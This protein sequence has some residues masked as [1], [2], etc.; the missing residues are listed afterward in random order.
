MNRRTALSLL[1]AG[2]GYAFLGAPQIVFGQD[3]GPV[4]DVA[5][6]QVP[7]ALD[8]LLGQTNPF[9]RTLQNVYDTLLTVDYSGDGALQPALAE[10]WTRVDGKTIDLVLRQ[11]VR[12]HDGSPLTVD[13]VIFSFG[14]ER[15]TNPDSPG[16][17]TAQQ[18]LRTI[19]TVEAVD[20][21]TIRVTSSADD[22][23]LE[24]RLT[25]WGSQIVSKAAFEAAGGFE[26]FGHAPVGTGPFSVVSL[27]P[28]LLELKAFADYWNGKPDIETL[29]YRSSPELSSRIA[30]VASGDFD[31]VVDVPV[32]QFDAVTRDP[33][34]EIVGGP[35]ASIRVIKFDTRNEVLKDVRVRKALALAVDRQA[36]VDALWG[37][38]VTIPHGHQLEE[39]GALYT[40]DRPGYTYDPE[41]AKRL[42]AEAGYDGTPIPYRIRAAAYGPELATAQVLVAM[43]NAVGVNIDLQIVENFGQM[44][45]YPGVGMRNGVDPILVADPLFGL[46]RSHDRGEAEIWSNEEFFRAGETLQTSLDPDVRKAAFNRMMDIYDFEDPPAFILHTMGTFYGKKK[47]VNWTPS[48]S[49]Y[50]DFRKASLT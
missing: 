50:M 41:E 46:W 1:G 11:G 12:F 48:K 30:G 2:A 33:N 25:A 35:V 47:T 7:A 24:L 26:G 15:R 37:G 14:A 28:D 9:Y 22:P 40:P 8:P 10:S 45:A 27:S 49:V 31:L 3:A 19:E 34:L 38:L 13:D 4:L 29:N 18:F 16:Y 23:T 43:W 17:G 20:D 32:D 6:D 36:I 39:F 21:K 5:L 44:V 42:L